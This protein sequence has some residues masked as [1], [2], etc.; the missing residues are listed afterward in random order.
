MKNNEV[1]KSFVEGHESSTEKLYTD[2]NKIY[3]K[4]IMIGE[5]WSDGKK[6]IYDYT[7]NNG[8]WIDQSLNM[9]IRSARKTGISLMNKNNIFVK[10]I[11][12][13]KN[14]TSSENML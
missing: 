2:G 5:T 13:K 7:G 3:Y 12:G 14:L 4:D 6:V 8:D 10:K 1:F 9:L 11:I